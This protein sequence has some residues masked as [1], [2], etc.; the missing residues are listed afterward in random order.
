MVPADVVEDLSKVK[1]D[2]GVVWVLW[3]DRLQQSSA[4]GEVL[5]SE[6]GLGQVK[7]NLQVIR[8]LL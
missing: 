3:S 2:S 4:I 8:L 7:R 5:H 1:L 6:V